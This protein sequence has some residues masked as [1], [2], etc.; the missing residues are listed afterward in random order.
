MR[1]AACGR[2]NTPDARFCAYCGA[3]LQPTGGEGLAAGQLVDGGHYCVLH[4]LASGGM[5]SVYLAKNTR[6]FDRLCVLKEMKPYSQQGEDYDAQVRFE[7][8][9]R[10]LANLKHPGIPDIYGY[11]GEGSRNYIVMQYI[12]GE[13]LESSLTH[14][15]AAGT[16]APG[17]ALPVEQGLG[18]AVEVCRVLEYLG[19]VTPQPV[20]H[21]DVKPAN[22]IIE[23]TT[24]RVVLV[25]FGT[26]VWLLPAKPAGPRA[27]ATLPIPQAL[28]GTPGY[29]APELYQGKAVPQSDVFSLAATLYHLLTDD[30]PR[31]H[32][33]QWPRMQ[34]LPPGP[35]RIVRSALATEIE[36][37]P[38]A[39]AL[40]HDLESLLASRG[41][42]PE[43]AGGPSIAG[44]TGPTPMSDW[45]AIN[46]RYVHPAR[47]MRKQGRHADAEQ[48]LRQGLADTSNDF[49]VALQ[50]AE[51]LSSLQR[52]EEAIRYF[53]LAIPGLKPN[54]VQRGLDGHRRAELGLTR[55]QPPSGRSVSSS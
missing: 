38:S 51:L 17:Q 9:A 33:F 44:A 29:A 46:S 31:Q 10:T 8:E 55:R 30:D 25:D 3:R 40:R 11:V 36:A 32:P 20:V 28:Y 21:C 22:I 54:Y 35:A 45:S 2:L 48:L 49:W 24:R 15:N 19:K 39:E 43:P 18:Y 4:P 14:E 7:Q 50:L 26:S 53:D 23:H 13:S 12:E 6:A 42:K 34:D 16:L 41:G 27:G 5:G 52:F 37:R 47:D 1:C